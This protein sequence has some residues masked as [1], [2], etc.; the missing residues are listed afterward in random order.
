MSFT[1]ENKLMELTPEQ[2]AQIPEWTKKWIE[3][4]LSTE[5][6]DFDA[7]TEAA[8]KAY[9]L[10]GY[11]PMVILRVSSP[12]AATIGG[13]LAWI[14]L[15]ELKLSKVNNQVLDQV[16]DQVE[17][18]VLDQVWDQVVTQV[19]SQV[20]TQVGSQV[21]DQV[22]NQVRAQV[23]DQVWKQVGD[24]VYDQVWEQVGDQVENQVL[25]QVVAHVGDHVYDQVVAQVGDQVRA[26]VG[27]QVWEQVRDHVWEQVG[28][29]V[30]NQ[31]GDQVGSQVWEQVYDQV[32]EQVW[33]QVNASLFKDAKD[34]LNNDGMSSLWC[35]FTSFAT[36]FRDV[37]GWG[38]VEILEKLA[39]NET[40][41]KSCGWTWWHPNVFVISDRPEHINR[42]TQGRLHS[43]T[44]SAIRYRDGWELFYIHGVHL[45]ESQKYIVTN[46]ELITVTGIESETNTE[47]RRVMME[48]Y[49]YERYMQDCN[50][51][52]VDSIPEDHPI[53]GLRT[54]RLLRKDIMDDE[55][56]IYIDVL[57]S[58]PEEDGSVKRYMLRV[59]PYAYDGEASSKCRAAL[60]STFRNDLDSQE[61]TYKDYKDYQPTFES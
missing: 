9:A 2:I 54:A 32:W 24:Q 14:L 7:A 3:I 43:L 55:P 61:L 5:P 49:G 60:A 38:D 17:N 48:R 51:V 10:C 31:V 42:D 52:I 29:Q 4:G 23:G 22:K 25:D 39:I 19:G 11:K 57:N 16:V 27:D 36:Y 34:G 15:T 40:L 46:P 21:R 28:G 20:V 1:K 47:V 45:N 26:Q 53:I 13:A 58:T 44:K 56:I 35:S 12:Y 30:K 8:L 59:D 6:A 50:A 37:C 41:I 18:Q 33:D